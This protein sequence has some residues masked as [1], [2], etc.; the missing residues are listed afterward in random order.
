M[1]SS[2]LSEQAV[3]ASFR[4]KE[5]VYNA[6]SVITKARS[7]ILNDTLAFESAPR[8]DELRR[9]LGKS[10][11]HDKREAMKRVV[12]QMSRGVDMHHLFP[13]VVKNIHVLCIET[14]KLIYLFVLRYAEQCPQAALLSIAAFQRDL[15]DPSMHVRS[16][17]LRTLSAIPIAT[18]HPV[19]ML[20]IRKAATDVAGLVRKTAAIALVQ[21]H[22]VVRRSASDLYDRHTAR[23]VL[24]GLLTDR[25]VEVLAAAVMAWE[26]V[27]AAEVELLHPVYRHLCRV[28]AECDEWG[29]VVLLR[30]LLRYARTQFCDPGVPSTVLAT[31]S[32]SALTDAALSRKG[33]HASKKHADDEAASN[34]TAH[35][36]PDKA[37]HSATHDEEGETA[38]NT[39][40]DDARS[41]RSTRSATE[42]SDATS[43]STSELHEWAA[44]MHTGKT[45]T[46]RTPITAST[47]PLARYTSHAAWAGASTQRGAVPPRSRPRASPHLGALAAAESER[48]G[49]SRCERVVLPRGSAFAA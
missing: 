22:R 19:V 13:D 14:R 25:S 12:A 28:L 37:H 18:V 41:T 48:G 39:K 32:G 49:G 8:I 35:G 1:P 23:E 43:S 42:S 38:V 9:A 21:A 47:S 45:G 40:G 17:A 6:S 33:G 7:L 3:S 24:R 34:N 29:Q 5:Y 10:S 15:S 44:D 30:V 31:A 11:V 4:A 16:L 46:P 2:T 27:F 36:A 26:G 20:A